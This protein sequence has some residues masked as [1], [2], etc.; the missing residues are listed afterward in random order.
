MEHY[1]I[2]ITDLTRYGTLYCVAGWDVERER[3]IRPEPPGANAAAEASRFW[4]TNFAGDGQVFAVGNKVQL[5]A[6][7]PPAHFPFPHATED[8]IVAAGSNITVLEHLN[9][10]QIIHQVG[11]SVSTS[12]SDAFGGHLIRSQNGK[13]Y[14]PAGAACPS[15]GAIEIE[16]DAIRFYSE[17]T[18]NGRLRLR[19]VVQHQGH[20]YDFSVPADAAYRRFTQGQMAALEADANASDSIHIR[21]GLSRPFAA[22]PCYAQINGL[23]FL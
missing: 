21:L 7:T 11:E 19:A 23:L 16:P 14:V 15:L 20:G 4:D 22:V 3:M 8:R 6:S 17:T 18:G 9:T 12:P 1:N 5:T 13:A 2:I 10:S